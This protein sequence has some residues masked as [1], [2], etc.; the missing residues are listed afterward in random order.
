MRPTT[1]RMMTAA[2][3]PAMAMPWTCDA[4]ESRR[5][6]GLQRSHSP[7]S[8]GTGAPHRTQGWVSSGMAVVGA[9]TAEM[10]P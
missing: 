8:S 2:A 4:D 5:P 7:T 3:T 1:A 10:V 6:S 9:V